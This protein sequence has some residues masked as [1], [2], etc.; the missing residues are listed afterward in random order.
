MEHKLFLM[1]AKTRAVIEEK[2]S[3]LTKEYR[4]LPGKAW[5]M[6]KELIRKY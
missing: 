5:M 3:F 6:L 2:A 4:T 1:E